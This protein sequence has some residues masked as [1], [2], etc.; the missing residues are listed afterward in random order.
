MRALLAV[1]MCCGGCFSQARGV[2]KLRGKLTL[3]VP[4]VGV[5]SDGDS[6]TAGAGVQ[7]CCYYPTVALAGMALANSRINTAVAGYTTQSIVDHLSTVISPQLSAWAGLSKRIYTLMIGTNDNFNTSNYSKI[8]TICATVVAAGASMVML[9]NLPCT[10]CNETNR[11]SWNTLIRNG[12][13]CS[14]TVADVGNDPTIGQAGNNLNLTY[15]QDGTHPTAAGDAIVATYL[16]TALNS[17][18]VN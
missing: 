17:L 15:Y 5:I 16:V 4:T 2:A 12:G 3:R 1:L 6:I 13:A 14:Y 9:T 8:Q 10:G 18:G 7:P 11:Q